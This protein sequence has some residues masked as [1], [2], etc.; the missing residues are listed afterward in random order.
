M[1]PSTWAQKQPTPVKKKWEELRKDNGFSQS[2]TYQGPERDLYTDPTTIN[3]NKQ[4]NQGSANPNYKPY[5]GIPLTNRQ[6]QKG[7]KTPNNPNGPGGSGTI[8]EDPNI[9]P[10]ESWD[11]PEIEPRKQNNLDING[12]GKNFWLYLGIIL[13]AIAAAFVIYQ[14]I[15]NKQTS[16]PIIPFEPLAEDLNPSTISKTEL[17]LRLEEAISKGDY[18]ECVRIYFLFAMKELIERRWIFWKKEKT[19]MHYIIEMQGRPGAFEFEKIVQIY[20][21]VWYGDYTIDQTIYATLEKELETAY[22]TIEAKQ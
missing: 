1:V 4:N 10:S 20:D 5:N 14:I 6:I 17:E 19:N 9:Q 12:P 11:S 15:K 18:K 22:K 8:K 2:E 3:E 16:D 21:V 13:L 7:R